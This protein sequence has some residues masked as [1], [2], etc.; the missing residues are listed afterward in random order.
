MLFKA[1]DIIQRD[2]RNKRGNKQPPQYFCAYYDFDQGKTKIYHNGE[3]EEY[4]GYS[5]SYQLPKNSI[6]F[7][8]SNLGVLKYYLPGGKVSSYT[9]K[10]EVL[11]YKWNGVSFRSFNG[12]C[13][14]QSI[15]DICKMFDVTEPV[16]AMNEFLSVF[17]DEKNVKRTLAATTKNMFFKDIKDELWEDVKENK[18]YFNTIKDW[19]LAYC[20]NKAG[21]MERSENF[22]L[23]DM[24]EGYDKK[25]AYPSYFV[26]DNKFPIGKLHQTKSP[27]LFVERLSK[28]EWVKVV[29]SGDIKGLGSWYDERTGMTA[30]EYYDIFSYLLSNNLKTLL[31]IVKDNKGIFVYSE[32]TGY[33]NDTFR[34]KIVELYNLKNSIQ[35]GS[36]Q[37]LLVKTQLDMLFGKSLQWQDF[38]SDAQLKHHYR[39]QGQNYLQPQHGNHVIAAMRYEMYKCLDICKKEDLLPVYHDTD[40]VKIL[41]NEKTKSIFE[42]LNSN[43]MKRNE[44]AGFKNLNIGIWDYEGEMEHFAY[45]GEK[46]YVFVQDK[47]PVFK[48]SGCDR[49][50]KIILEERFL[51]SGVSMINDWI[52]NGFWY[53]LKRI[54]CDEDLPRIE[55]SS[56]RKKECEIYTLYKYKENKGQNI[57]VKD[58]WFNVKKK[59]RNCEACNI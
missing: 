46:Q 37:Y 4:E 29:F 20:G 7:M 6:V 2:K 57:Q 30:L 24:C 55:I 33:L 40:G 8:N 35:K 22:C 59:E 25:S 1:V 38:K 42:Q 44:D 49:E 28:K 12:I 58:V 45:F 52:T 31:Q 15:E 3:I 19:K 14:R 39:G 56:T 10:K 21:L 32:K 27:E 9:R 16:I 34:R 5:F 48:I 51:K 18:S 23:A 17:G 26:N 50:C 43:I 13:N 47:K 11:E 54:I 41:K 36:P 53:P